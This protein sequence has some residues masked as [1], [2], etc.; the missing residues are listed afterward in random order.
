MCYINNIF[1]N[2]LKIN[3]YQILTCYHIFWRE[4]TLV[5]NRACFEEFQKLN[6]NACT[7]ST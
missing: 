1:L 6:I 4:P 3:K 2:M 5:R 7:H